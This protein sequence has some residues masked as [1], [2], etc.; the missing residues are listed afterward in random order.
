MAG[1]KLLRQLVK[2]GTAGDVEVFKRVSEE[3]I[4]EERQKQHHLLA[5]DLEHILYGR[6]KPLETT[7]LSRL[8]PTVPTDKERGLPLLNLRQDSVCRGCC[9]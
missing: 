9:L 3:V 8:I 7:G 1:G 4:R 6:P 5:N 2:A